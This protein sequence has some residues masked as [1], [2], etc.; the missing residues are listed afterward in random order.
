MK[1]FPQIQLNRQKTRMKMM[2]AQFYFQAVQYL[3]M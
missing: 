3:K 1:I 2:K